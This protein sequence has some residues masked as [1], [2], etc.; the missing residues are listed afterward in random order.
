MFRRWALGWLR[1]DLTAYTTL[2]EKNNLAMK[3]LIQQRLVHWKGDSD[4]V[5]VRDAQALD[6]LPENERAAWQSLW[7]DVHELLTRVEKRDEPAKGRQEPE[8]P[9][10]KPEGR[11]LPPNG[12]LGR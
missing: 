7:R 1:D 5:S 4:L 12:A 6:R 11:S 3:Q 8:N 10:T 9:K 2:A